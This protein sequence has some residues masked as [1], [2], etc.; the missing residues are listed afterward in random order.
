MGMIIKLTSQDVKSKCSSK[1]D[2]W[3]RVRAQEMFVILL[4]RLG[5]MIP[6]FLHLHCLPGTP[7]VKPK[8]AFEELNSTPGIQMSFSSHHR[9]LKKSHSDISACAVYIYKNL[10]VVFLFAA[11]FMTPVRNYSHFVALLNFWSENDTGLRLFWNIKSNLKD[12]KW[13]ALENIGKMVFLVLRQLGRAAA[14]PNKWARGL[15]MSCTLSF[16]S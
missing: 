8:K 13:T 12:W 15:P 9:G 14:T 10:L 6:F 11:R 4:P 1:C 7:C 3:H 5:T 2:I 16:G